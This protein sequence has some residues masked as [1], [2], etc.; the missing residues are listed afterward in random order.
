MPSIRAIPTK[1]AG[2][3]FRSRAEARW[4]RCFDALGIEWEYE[5]EGYNLPSGPYLPDFL[6]PSLLKPC[7]LEV[8]GQEPNERERTVARE[9]AG[10]T[11]LRVFIAIRAPRSCDPGCEDSMEAFIPGPD[12]TNYGETLV[13]EDCPY[14]LCECARCGKFGIEYEGRSARIGCF[15]YDP[16]DDKQYNHSSDRIVAALALARSA[17]FGT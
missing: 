5:P 3:S 11:G 13:D 6:L 10:A 9:L 15:C 16:S 14:W 8:K 2:V 7:F 17:R 4:A 12:R 1:Y